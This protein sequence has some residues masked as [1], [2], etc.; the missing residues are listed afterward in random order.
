MV[1]FVQK[2][3]ARGVPLLVCTGHALSPE[4]KEFLKKMYGF[5]DYVYTKDKVQAIKDYVK[6]LQEENSCEIKRVIYIDD[7]I[8]GLRQ[9]ISELQSDLPCTGFHYAYLAQHLNSQTI[10]DAYLD[11]QNA[12]NNARKVAYKYQ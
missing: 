5:H 8:E 2:L 11:A 4:K 7:Y 10:V 9:I 12:L 1:D 6:K 3:R